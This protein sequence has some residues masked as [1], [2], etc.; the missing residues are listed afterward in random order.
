MNEIDPKDEGKCVLYRQDIV[1][2]EVERVISVHPAVLVMAAVLLLVVPWAM[3]V[4]QV[5]KYLWGLL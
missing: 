3:G 4:G 2:G 1:T 5:L